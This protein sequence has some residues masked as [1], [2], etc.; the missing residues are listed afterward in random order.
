MYRTIHEHLQ[1]ALTIRNFLYT[2]HYVLYDTYRVL[3]DT[4][5]SGDN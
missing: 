4:D 1:Y 3:Y 5:N 2:M